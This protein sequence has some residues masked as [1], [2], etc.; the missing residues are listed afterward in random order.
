MNMWSPR[1]SK[2]RAQRGEPPT[3]GDNVF[4]ILV[5]WMWLLVFMFIIPPLLIF[6]LIIIAM[7]VG[8]A[9]NIGLTLTQIVLYYIIGLVAFS[10]VWNCIEVRE[11]NR[12]YKICPE[13]RGDED[14]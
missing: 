13:C 1:E 6:N 12:K 4:L 10:I 14:G 5:G 7:W 8:I 3:R 9:M 11:I 2:K